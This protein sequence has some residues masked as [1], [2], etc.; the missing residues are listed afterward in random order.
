MPCGM[1]EKYRAISF[2]ESAEASVPSIRNVPEAGLSSPER[3]RNSVVL[4]APLAPTRHVNASSEMT[5]VT[6]LRMVLLWL[7]NDSASKLKITALAS[8][9]K[10]SKELPAER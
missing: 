2:G 7:T 10:S 9:H 5:V 6:L 8:L 3:A 1:T 4:P